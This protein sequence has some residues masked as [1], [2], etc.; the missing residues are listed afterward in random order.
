MINLA[1][2]RNGDEALSDDPISI[3]PEFHVQL[4]YQAMAVET[5]DD[6]PRGWC[7]S[8]LRVAMRRRV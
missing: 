5:T 4:G 3:A 1:G 2:V 7:L 6:E 8:E